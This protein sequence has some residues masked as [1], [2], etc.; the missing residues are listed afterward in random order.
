MGADHEWNYS[1]DSKTVSLKT[2][3]EK[4]NVKFDVTIP[5]GPKPGSD[6]IWP[7][8]MVGEALASATMHTIAY[9]HIQTHRFYTRAETMVNVLDLKTAPVDVGYIMGSG[10][11]VPDAIR[12]MGLSVAMLE[13]K[14]LASGDLS[15]FDTI[16]VG[17]RASET[18]PDFVANSGRLLEY[19]KN[20]GNLIVQYQRPSFA[21]Q[22]LLPYPATLGPRVVDE[23]AK[24]TILQP[25]HPA[26]NSPNKI[27]ANDSAGWVQ[28]RNLYNLDKFDQ[29]M[30]LPLLESHD[31]G[32]PENRGGLVIAKVGDGTFV[33]CSY[34]FFRQLPAGVGG[35]YRLF[36]NL[37]SLPKATGK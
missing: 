31:A 24:V 15:R 25:E 4:Q 17:I 32:E 35:A 37:L 21:Q 9:P 27:S 29:A 8:F 10:D 18:R 14:D 12:Q 5:A 16:V 28:E 11:E 13:E 30:Y 6:N 22:K 2:R 19:V 34:S 1:T 20:G 36:A 3:G 26:F 23:N 33:Y 7:N